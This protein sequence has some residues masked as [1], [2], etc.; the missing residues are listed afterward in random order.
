MPDRWRDRAAAVSAALA[1]VF[2]DQRHGLY[3]VTS[4]RSRWWHRGTW[5]YWWQAHALD[6]AVDA[7]E[8]ETQEG[9]RR[10][11]LDRILRH[12]DGILR[13]NGGDIRNDYYDDMA[14]M[15]LAL[16][17][18]DEVA[19]AGTRPLVETLWAA[20][21]G[22]WDERGGLRWR[23][24]GAPY[25]NTP[26]NGPAAILAARLGRDDW[27]TRIAGWL[28]E[29]LVRAD[30]VVADGVR[31]D[32][33]VDE[34]VWSYC[35]GLA[36]GAAVAVAGRGGDP[37]WTGRAER[38]AAAGCAAVTDAASGLWRPEGGHDGGLFR[39]VLA[40]YLAEHALAAPDAAAR[41]GSVE[42][43]V[44]NGDAVWRHRDPRGLVG[45]D[46]SRAPAG[47]VELSV[48]LSGVLLLEALARLERHGALPET[49]VA[50]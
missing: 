50:G 38:T 15:A 26:A 30:G 44:R 22:G 40:R 42:A 34:T 7:F 46:W 32:G 33:G 17:R 25:R 39:G 19:G 45:E 1:E 10:R 13:R 21:E 20:I 23:T 47:P 8:R 27:A 31:D 11:V 12:V 14:W 2:W 43:L 36:V 48:H 35:Q 5:H 29:H 28:H 3:A 16:L 41:D 24:S 9:V 18:A 4:R 6:A 37:A 49:G